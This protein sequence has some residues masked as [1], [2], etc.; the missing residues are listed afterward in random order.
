MERQIRDGELHRCPSCELAV[1]RRPGLCAPCERW[2]A[3]QRRLSTSGLGRLLG[4]VY[5]QAHT[6]TKQRPRHEPCEVSHDDMGEHKV[7]RCAVEYI[8]AADTLLRGPDPDHVVDA[9]VRLAA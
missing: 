1:R 7:G 3:G 4:A 8:R 9:L 6:D 2:G 5:A